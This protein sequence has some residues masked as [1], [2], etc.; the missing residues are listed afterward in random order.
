MQQ[1]PSPEVIAI[2]IA[3]IFVGGVVG[4][5]IG[6][7]LLRMACGVCR[8][9]APGF[10]KAA[11]LVVLMFV[12]A[13]GVSLAWAP[14]GTVVLAGRPPSEIQLIS[15]LVIWPVSI[16]LQSVAL[17]FLLPARWWRAGLVATVYTLI[18]LLIFAILTVCV[19]LF[20]D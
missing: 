2:M 4:V 3:S 1:A 16:V 9:G 17:M 6:A 13:L 15:N 18:N 19:N 11:G 8:V 7:M 20:V 12:L 14:I 5:G 10:W